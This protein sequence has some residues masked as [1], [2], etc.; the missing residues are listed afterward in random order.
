MSNE[1]SLQNEVSENKSGF[2]KIMI[3]ILIFFPIVLSSLLLGAHFNKAGWLPLVIFCALLPFLLFIKR[4]WVARLVQIVL[5]LGAIEW[6]RITIVIA[7]GRIDAG[8]DWI[9]LV[10][11]LG[12]VA[13]FTF[14]S[15]MLF[16]WSKSLKKIYF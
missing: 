2:G 9:R 14:L 7:Q 4:V 12:G 8:D 3:H 16:S 1:S 5:I 15:G 11:I 10:I 6:I 13:L